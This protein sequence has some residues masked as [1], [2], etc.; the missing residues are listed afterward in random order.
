MHNPKPL[1]VRVICSIQI[2]RDADVACLAESGYAATGEREFVQANDAEDFPDVFLIN[3]IPSEGDG[4][5]L[6]TK[7]RALSER[8]GILV[9]IS[10]AVRS[11]KVQALLSGADNFIVRPYTKQELLATVAGLSRRLRN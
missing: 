5:A 3:L 11:H 8:V 10:Q 4:F 1:S 2:H 9:V 6:T 7:I